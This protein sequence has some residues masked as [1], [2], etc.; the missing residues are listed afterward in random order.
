MGPTATPTYAGLFNIDHVV[1]DV[2]TGSC[3]TAGI[4]P[5]HPDVLDAVYFDHKP[6][7]CALDLPSP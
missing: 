2:A 4:S 3:W 1:S 6:V 5:G 7:V